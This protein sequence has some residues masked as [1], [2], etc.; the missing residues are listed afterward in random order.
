MDFAEYPLLHEAELMLTLLRVAEDR[1]GR[2]EDALA[3]LGRGL[4]RAGEPAT[5][6]AAEI[7]ARLEAARLRL[8]VAGL[9][10]EGGGGGFR[11][12]TRG[13]KVLA[14]HPD[15]VD[16]TVLMQFREFRLW[17]RQT[18]EHPPPEDNAGRAYQEGWMAQLAGRPH[19]DNPYLGDTVRH[20]AWENGWFEARDEEVDHQP[21]AREGW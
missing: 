3:R 13:R 19:S 4:D 7:T 9:L 8:C 5:L 1:E 20:Q 11:I 17:L 21:S 12:S 14:E 18:A 6:S 16:D 15:G 2:V 10:C